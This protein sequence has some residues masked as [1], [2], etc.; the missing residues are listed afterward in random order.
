MHTWFGE[1]VF[2]ITSANGIE[3][4]SVSHANQGESKLTL[5]KYTFLLRS[6]F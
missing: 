1:V 4:D 6:S 5:T 3:W 2:I